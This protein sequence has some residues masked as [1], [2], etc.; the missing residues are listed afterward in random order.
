MSKTMNGTVVSKKTDKTIVVAVQ[1]HKIHP[2]Y[3]K[4]YIYSKR[5]LVHDESN[6]ANLGD[7]VLIKPSRPLSARKRFVFVSVQNKAAIKHQEP[8]NDNLA[9]EKEESTT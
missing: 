5:F 3:K 6:Q 1:V 8:E 4:S 7:K 2:V 9:A